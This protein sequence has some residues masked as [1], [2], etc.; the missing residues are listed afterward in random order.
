MAQV[1]LYRGDQTASLPATLNDGAIYVVQTDANTGEIYADINGQRIKI[2]SGSASIFTK[3]TAQWSKT[4][5]LVSAAGTVYIYSDARSY[6]EQYVKNGQTLT[7][8]VQVPG[9]KIGDGT[10]YVVDLPFV[11]VTAQQINF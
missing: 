11:N 5:N 3:T 10:S 9:L 1:K 6:E 8:T 2:S 7:R 4:P